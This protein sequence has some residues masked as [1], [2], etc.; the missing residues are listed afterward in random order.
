[1]AH[2]GDAL[3][4]IFENNVT[5]RKRV[6]TTEGTITTT[7]V[8]PTDIVNK[9]YC[10]NNSS[11]L[12]YK[13]KASATDLTA[14][15]LYPKLEAGTGIT[16]S[17]DNINPYEKVKIEVDPTGTTHNLL[18][19]QHSDTTPATPPEKGDLIVGNKSLLGVKT[20]KKF[21][22]TSGSLTTALCQDDP[23][24]GS[25]QG[26]IWRELNSGILSNYFYL[27]GTSA[28]QTGYGSTQASGNLI[29]GSTSHATKGETKIG[30]AFVVDEANKKIIL[31][32]ITAY[33]VSLK[34]SASQTGDTEYI[35]PINKA[36]GIDEA[37][38]CDPTTAV[39]SW[40][41]G[42]MPTGTVIMFA[43]PNAPIGYVRC[44]GTSYLKT[45]LADLYAVIGTTFGGNATHF[46]VP[47]LQQRFIKGYDGIGGMYAVGYTAGDPNH[48]HTFTGDALANHNHPFTG[49]AL[50]THQHA[51][52]SAGTPAGSIDAHTSANVNI[53]VPTSARVTGP[54]THTFTGSALASHQHDAITA[55]TPSGTNT[56]TSGG[57]ASGS[58]DTVNSEPE[59]LVLNYCIK[60]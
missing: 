8:N 9:A 51:G 55:G 53:S 16:I 43:T 38:I 30:S 3:N 4:D 41:G 31:K 27:P 50:A 52:K 17:L 25:D 46:N 57:T 1:M 33:K 59:Y 36:V 47:D 49:D 14:D 54:L 42:L 60:T 2:R 32:D 13:V 28:G 5:V 6:I 15:F 12:D 58:I 19:S 29:L 48:N 22:L 7:P 18:S 11:V 20:W 35:L 37:L 56:A 26:V 23:A 39:L 40:K 21:S 44:D 45:Y 34:P 24:T 10:D